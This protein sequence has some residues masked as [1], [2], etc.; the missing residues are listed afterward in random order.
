MSPS[1]EAT[2]AGQTSVRTIGPILPADL[3]TRVLVGTGLEGMTSGDF[4]LELGLTPR[5]AANRAWAVLS[6]AWTAFRDAIAKRPE[7]DPSTSLTREKWE[8]I[9]LRELGYGRVAPATGGLDADGRSFPVSHCWN[10]VVPMHL[11]GWRVPL[12]RP[13]KGLAG[14]AGRAPHSMVQ[15]LLNRSEP[16]SWAILTNGIQ[17][18]LLRD[19]MALVGQSYVEFD[20]EAIF[21]GE[22]FADFA[23][24]FLL[25]HQS[26]LEPLSSENHT[27]CWLERWRTTVAAEGVRAL[28][29]L[30]E[31]VRGAI[32][33][34]GSGFANHPA[35]AEL[36]EQI[37]NRSLDLHDY[38]RALLRLVYRLLFCFVAEDRGL[39]LLPDDPADEQAVR[40]Q[41]ATA[42]SRYREWFSTA[43]LRRTAR[44]NRG[45]RHHD[46]WQALLLVLN[47]LGSEEGLPQLALP[48]L[49][50]LFESG[51]ADVV[52]GYELSNRS[53][54]AAIRQLSYTTDGRGGAL[55]P[56][57]YANLGA[58]ELGGIY[59]G[60]LEFVPRWDSTTKSFTLANLAG[61][62]RRTS[63]AYYTPSSLID[64]LLD[65]ALDPLLDRAVSEAD[66]QRTLLAITV[67]DPA[68]G[69]GH[70]LVAAARRIAARLAAVR[71]G[72][73]EPNTLDSQTAMHDVVAHCIYG[74]DASP[75]AAELA[76]MSLWLEALQPGRPL[77][78]L[79][80][81]IKVGNSLLGATPSLL[82]GGIPDEAFTAIEGDDR[83]LVANL[84]KRNQRERAGQGGL[85]A[86]FGLRVDTS[87]ITQEASAID[88]LPTL[89]L[90]DVHLAAQRQRQLD[91]SPE[92]RHARFMADAWCAAFLVP[93][94]PQRPEITE[95]LLR[96][97]EAQGPVEVADGDRARTAVE[98][99][100]ASY[101]LFHWHLEF[102]QIFTPD[103]ELPGPGWKGGFTCVIGNPPWEKV[104]LSEKE[105]FASKDPEIASLPGAKRKDRIGR[106]KAE[107]PSLWEE[108]RAAL[109]I[110]EAESAFLRKSGRYPLCGRGDVNTYS[111]FAEAML[112][113][114]ALTGR[115]GAIVPTGIATDD[116]TKDFFANCVDHGQLVSLFDFRNRG[117]FPDV[118][119]AQGNRFCLLTLAGRNYP[120]VEAEFLFFGLSLSELANRERRF[121]LTPEDL[122]LI[123]P[124]T[125]TAPVFRSNHDAELTK[126]IYRR[127]P[128]LVREGDSDGNPWGIEYQRMFEMSTDSG[129]FTTESELTALG[130]EIG[131]NR[132][133]KDSEAWLPL[134]EAKMVHHFNHRFGD[135]ALAHLTGK[136]VR[137][138]PTPDESRLSNFEYRV[139]PRYWVEES[140]VLR[141]LPYPAGWLLGFRDIASALDE[142]TMIAAALPCVGVGH[143]LP[144]LWTTASPTLTSGLLAIFNSFVF[145]YCVRQKVGGTHMTLFVLK[146]FAVL[147]PTMLEQ[148]APWK[149]NERIADWLES[150]VLELTYTA[151]DMAGFAT[152][153]DY[154][155]PPFRWDP[156][157]RRQLRAEIDAACLH[158]Y[159]LDRNDA[160]YIMDTF[161][162]TRRKDVATYG[163]YL[164]KRLVL[165]AYDAMATA[166]VSG[167]PYQSPLTPPPGDGP[168]HH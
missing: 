49:G 18:R 62:E 85:F 66:P 46:Q 82:A 94:Q 109:R 39:L 117:F 89:S 108:F 129:H 98:E 124:N 81:H 135:Y 64:C 67:C 115:L 153:L 27:D 71:A 130:A 7:D 137:Q 13:T 33:A 136:E 141:Q 57:D 52:M 34:L 161:L 160:A 11:L 5:E 127:V 4:H 16:F 10:N 74:V 143:N 42:R 32:E 30:R 167:Q 24:L 61:N 97:W 28:G 56:I 102:P 43:R 83:R 113:M 91:A 38:H 23:L 63:G 116:T 92:L 146:Q 14:A 165:E 41:R 76:K 93:K 68:C 84:K 69:S 111:V 131:G 156:E 72:G 36:Y 142:R 87:G 112:D 121:T 17:L 55:R 154:D 37:E 105:F 20:L 106:L 150:R 8:T 134:Y 149:S 157:R 114:L 22:V 58:E 163:E 152:A 26:R 99:V 19:S 54:F 159:G 128:V 122:A 73:D 35:N 96:Q 133:K 107:D 40:Q 15:E 139:H 78:H 9:L 59:E 70:F 79:D 162:I 90:A 12:D 118:A 29:D 100:A 158:L 86:H 95:A 60:L 148:S 6:G 44:R 132:W 65:S 145:D 77:S 75:M 151:F 101:R 126:K 47:G 110:A 3:L 138:L 80:G 1:F 120:A 48:A 123:N 88:A 164:T 144:I 147:P 53:L 155:G 50:G 119:G 2:T 25:C 125:H 103:E 31:G 104:K 168:R 51:P 166:T 140:Q 21:D 45:G